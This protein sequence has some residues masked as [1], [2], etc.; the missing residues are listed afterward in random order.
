L[1]KWYSDLL[2][3]TV[4]II[5]ILE[6]DTS[7]SRNVAALD[8]TRLAKADLEFLGEKARARELFVKIPL[9]I[10]ARLTSIDYCAAE[11][12]CPHKLPIGEL[13]AEA[14]KLLA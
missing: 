14:S 8:N 4:E 1:R 6:H 9:D 5:H 13:M 12:R 3:N 10:R 11:V 2:R 7:M